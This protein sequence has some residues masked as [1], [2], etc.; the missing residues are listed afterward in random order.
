MVKKTEDS[1]TSQPVFK[2]AYT[3]TQKVT[4]GPYNPGP[5][6]Q[7]LKDEC[8]VN[9]IVEKYMRSGVL[10][11]NVRTSQGY[12]DVSGIGDYEQALTTVQR[13]EDS[14]MAL[15]AALRARF[16]NDPSQFLNAMQDPTPELKSLLI[17]LGLAAP[18]KKQQKK[19]EATPPKDSKAEA[20]AE[21]GRVDT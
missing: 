17:K 14:F 7:S 2:H 12:M 6:E 20:K 21:A 10:P 11:S 9:K 18:Q 1:P 3:P 15:P 13:A 4:S 16:H 8:D 19:S 5:A